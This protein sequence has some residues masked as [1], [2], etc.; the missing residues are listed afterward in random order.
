MFR[1]VASEAW[2]MRHSGASSSVM[3]LDIREIDGSGFALAWPIFQA[4][5]AA[6]DTY[7]YDPATTF[8]EARDLWTRRPAR[9]F[10]ARE[11]DVVVGAYC[12]KPNQLGL[13]DHVANAGYMVAP[14]ARGRGIARALCAHSLD[15]ARA[16]GF[17]AMQFNF[18]AAT[19]AAAIHVWLRQGFKIVG[20]VPAAFRH[21]H[22]GLVDVLVMHQLL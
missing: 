2:I 17:Q 7:P 20:R 11:G 12:L 9:C 15:V 18:V 22:L 8:E 10:V 16:A 3:P 13:G 6:G 4:V 21:S 5:V 1:M 14:E 19:N